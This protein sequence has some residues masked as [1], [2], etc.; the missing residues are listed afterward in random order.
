M[1]LC[2]S[3]ASE[4]TRAGNR[5]VSRESASTQQPRGFKVATASSTKQQTAGIYSR[6][7]TRASICCHF[8]HFA[9]I[10][11]GVF[12]SG[13][14]LFLREGKKH[15]L[16]LGALWCTP[17]S[18]FPFPSLSLPLPFNYRSLFTTISPS[19]ASVFPIALKQHCSFYR[20]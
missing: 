5:R 18:S 13:S 3:F 16:R 6:L 8:L 17:I 15:F 12:F 1:N 14:L 11:F 2:T 9:T 19:L 4:K 7:G 10:F 20:W